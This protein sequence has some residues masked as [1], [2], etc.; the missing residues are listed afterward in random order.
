[1]GILDSLKKGVLAAVDDMVTPESFKIGEAFENYV[2]ENIFPF[3]HY[4]MLKKTHDY[5]Q[6]SKDYVKQSNEPDFQFESIES[7]K[8]FYLEAK[9]RSYVTDDNKVEWCKPN[10]LERY[11]QINKECPVFVLIGLG[12]KPSEPELISLMA[13]KHIKYPA[14]F[15]SILE[16][17]EV[18]LDKP[19]SPDYLWSLL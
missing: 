3:S 7:R 12:G 9:Y 10:Q 8:N 5:K 2:R 1:M 6:N 15:V 14:L 4:K 17:H 19:V 11:A 13:V 16:K 18:K